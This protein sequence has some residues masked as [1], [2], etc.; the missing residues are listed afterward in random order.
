MSFPRV[1]GSV[2]IVVGAL[3]AGA[4]SLPAQ[5][6]A[7]I[8]VSVFSR[9]MWRS[10]G[11]FRSGA[12]TAASGSTEPGVFFEGVA[13]AG[14]WKTSDNGV[15]WD[16]VFD[17]PPHGS[18]MSV[19]VAP[20]QSAVVYAGLGASAATPS[21]GSLYRSND[22]G[23]TW[24]ST[25]F[26]TTGSVVAIAIDARDAAH[27]WIAVACAA[28]AAPAD[29]GLYQ[30]TNGGQSFVPSTLGGPST[31]ARAVL[32]DPAN[33]STLY[34]VVDVSASPDASTV[35]KSTNGGAGWRP[36][37]SG[38]PNAGV[39]RHLTVALAPSSTN[40]LYATADV[41][42]E[43][44]VF[45]SDDGGANWSSTGAAMAP[46]PNFS[47]GAI[48]VDRENADTVLIA[49]GDVWASADAGRSLTRW[50]APLDGDPRFIARGPSGTV[51]IGGA[52]GLR[53]SVNGGRTWSSGFAQPTADVATVATDGAFPFRVC[54]TQEGTG[55]VCVP[56]RVERDRIGL[57]QWQVIPLGRNTLP[58][59]NDPD[60][61]YDGSGARFDRRTAQVVDTGPS[62]F[63]GRADAALAFSPD[64]RTIY[65][66]DRTI[67]RSVNAGQSWTT[68]PVSTGSARISAMA[69]SSIDARTLWAGATDGT[70]RVSRDSGATWT[71]GTVAAAAAILRLEPSHFDAQ[72][73]YATLASGPLLVRTR[74][75]GASWQPIVNGLRTAERVFVV[76][77]DPFRRGLLL[78]GTDRSIFASFD[79]GESWQPWGLNLPGTSVRDLTIRDSTIVVATGGRG[80]WA[81]DDMSPLRQLTADV[82]RADAFL[83]RPA[84]AYRLRAVARGPVAGDAPMPAPAPEG[85]TL[86]FLIGRNARGPV[87]LEIIETAADEVIRRYDL[88]ADGAAGLHQIV[89][90]LRYGPPSPA[91]GDRG[92][93]V[94]PATYQVRLTVNGRP[95]RQAVVVRMD[96]RLRA[97]A[98]D[99]TA[100]L[101]LA[102]RLATQITE[103]DR[104]LV[105]AAPERRAA[106]VEA[107]GALRVLASRV[108]RAD[109]RPSPALDADAASALSRAMSA[110]GA[111]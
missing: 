2:A 77:E 83:F 19:A 1:A 48:S 38:L 18:V 54:G 111:P 43:T 42:S 85:A 61:L 33:S 15:S 8:D 89:W 20:S 69:V 101:T 58:D 56:S 4:S 14:L 41:G 12:A 107:L 23:R 62:D 25:P 51:A 47:A 37:V 97:P 46:G 26:R 86:S 80:F 87:T 32:L 30:S 79:D 64:G 36:I 21:P 17:A 102:R 105:T 74:D 24:T 10:L 9:M 88:T 6:A 34:A 60:V 57:P 68:L 91:A 78:A 29:C 106:L 45:R 96:P 82:G 28:A 55:P 16:Q 52:N 35:F 81:L 99:L 73:A 22:E 3:I 53:I 110:V 39:L 7:A 98:A 103:T 67:R 44:Q 63:E 71:S 40:R 65:L 70:V 66:A 72:S 100:Q 75:G 49:A 11:P 50:P 109:V 104:A 95:L 59:P 76:R 27:I 5:P 84:P 94:L 31:S 90:D 92:P 108:E 13:G 93:L